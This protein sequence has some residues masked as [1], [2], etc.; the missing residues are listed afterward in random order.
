M[1]APIGSETR[2]LLQ[3]V[4][5]VLTRVS[6]GETVDADWL[7]QQCSTPLNTDI[8]PSTSRGALLTIPEACERL[9]I[10]RWSFYQLIHQQRLRTVTIG[11]R[12]FVPNKE[13]ERFVASL[14]ANG[15]S[16]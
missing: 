2:R 4:A 3:L 11:T 14:S 8:T 16:T 6:E 7:R 13:V 1:T 9:R 12:R 5:E 10:S 15:G